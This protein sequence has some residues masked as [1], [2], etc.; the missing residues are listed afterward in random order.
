[1]WTVEELKDI[2]GNGYD[3]EE[4]SRLKDAV[5]KLHT[6][7]Y[8]IQALSNMSGLS[9]RT[10]REFTW[11]R[12]KAQRKSIDLIRSLVREKTTWAK[13]LVDNYS[14]MEQLYEIEPLK[15]YKEAIKDADGLF[16]CPCP[17]CKIGKMT[18]LCINEDKKTFYCSFCKKSGDVICLAAAFYK[19]TQ[20]DAMRRIDYM[21]A[22]REYGIECEKEW[23]K[24]GSDKNVL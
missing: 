1:M 16:R 3:L 14:I 10:I 5:E 8:S 15:E 20:I 4:I 11:G 2:Y 19:E 17:L 18:A 12:V 22:N 7:G 6:K 9:G 23:A 24:N 21:I 13:E